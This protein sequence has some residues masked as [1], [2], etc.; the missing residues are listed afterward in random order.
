VTDFEAVW[1]RI[2]R[3]AGQE[4]ETQTGLAFTYAVPGDFLRITRDGHEINRSLSKTNFRKAAED[5]PADGPGAISD[6]QGS[7]YT[8]AILMDSRVRASDW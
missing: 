8:W 4:F 3:S 7:S 2:R 5:M 6:R 1:D